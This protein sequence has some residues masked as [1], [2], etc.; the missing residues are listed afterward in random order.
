VSDFQIALRNGRISAKRI[1]MAADLVILG[2]NDCTL[3]PARITAIDELFIA[4]KHLVVAHL[5]ITQVPNHWWGICNK[6][7][8]LMPS[9]PIVAKLFPRSSRGVT[10]V[11]SL[12]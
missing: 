12:K 7:T 4:A 3:P 9:D 6:I 2:G 11:S 1:Y 5:K 10:W 8:V